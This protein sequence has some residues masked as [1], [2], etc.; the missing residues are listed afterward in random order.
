MKDEA[1]QLDDQAGADTASDEIEDDDQMWDDLTS[2][3]DTP[4]SVDEFETEEEDP[5]I[6]SKPAKDEGASPSDES[7]TDNDS[8]RTQS[9]DELA[10][11]VNRLEKQ[12]NDEKGRSAGKDR[13]ISELNKRLAQAQ[14]S[15]TELDDED[16]GED[17][18]L[19]QI[20]EDYG[21]VVGPLVKRIEALNAK[22]G[23]LSSAQASELESLQDQR[24]AAVAEEEQVL[25][26]EH[27]DWRDTLSK[28][29]EDFDAWVEDQPKW[30]RD[31]RAANDAD[32]TNGAATALL[33]SKFKQHLLSRESASGDERLQAKQGLQ[34]D[35]ARTKRGRGSNVSTSEMPD[36]A[37][38]DAIWD[39]LT[40]GE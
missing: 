1:T 14:D 30:L 24:T 28:N 29:F 8:V 40:R 3:E 19:T 23:A 21:D 34:K 5:D 27:P 37:D 11:Q 10:K 25:D 36:D 2:E 6:S 16:A 15:V 32:I 26:E 31:I 20:S 4:A 12:L 39:D 17:D 7:P 38:E 18:D 22:V 13:R 35:G 33:V 9:P